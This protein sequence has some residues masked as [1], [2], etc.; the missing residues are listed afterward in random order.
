MNRALVVVA[1]VLCALPCLAQRST[2]VQLIHPAGGAVDQFGSVVAVSGDTMVV[3][4]PQDDV[5][6]FSDQGSVHVYRWTGTGW[7]FEATLIGSDSTGLDRFGW[8]VG[9]SG[10]TAVVGAYQDDGLSAD[11]G[12]AFV[13]IRT[14]GTSTWT[15]QAKL[16]A[17]DAA[18]A[19]QFGFS[20]AISGNTVV[21]G[22]NRDDVGASTDQ[23]SAYVFVRAGAIWTQQQ[24]LTASD[25]LGSDAMG[26]AVAIDGDTIVAAASNDAFGANG[27]QGSA[28]V[29]TRTGATWSQQQ[30]LFASD[31]AALDQ[32]GFSV[33]LSVTPSGDI[34]LV[35]AYQDDVGVNSNQ[36][37]A[38]VFVRSPGTAT[39]TQ[40]TKLTASDGLADDYFGSAVALSTGPGGDTALIGAYQD[41]TGANANQGAAYAFLRA[42][43]AT[44]WTQQSK[45]T[46][47]DGAAADNFG[48]AVALCGD[49]ALV[50]ANNDDLG[51]N[52]NQ[53]SAWVFSRVGSTWI[54]PDTFLS[55]STASANDFCGRSVA[56]SGDTAVVGAERPDF[57]GA[58]AQPGSAYV[59]VRTGSTWTQQAELFPSDS[60]TQDIFGH[61]VDISGD[62]VIVGNGNF[63]GGGAYI[64]V[65][66]GTT[67]SQQARLIGTDTVGFDAFGYAV[68]ISGDTAIVG[69]FADDVGANGNQGS[70]YVFVR[71]GATWTQQ[72]RLN[73]SD[74]AADDAFGTSVAI[75]GDSIVIGSDFDD[76]GANPSQGSAYCF[77]RSGTT[78]TQQQKLTDPDG[79]ASD[80]FGQDVAIAGDTIVVGS[81]NDDVG[82]RINQGSAHVFVR[83][84]GSWTRQAVLTASDGMGDGFFGESVAISGSTILAGSSARPGGGAVYVFSRSG[85]AWNQSA[86]LTE[87]TPGSWNGDGSE[88]SDAFGSGV[89]ISGDVA[90]V[91]AP[92]A[93]SGPVIDRGAAYTFDA[94]ASGY[95]LVRNDSAGQSFSSLAGALLVAGNG[96]QLAATSAAFSGIAIL[97]TLGRSFSISS[98]GPIRT[99][100]TSV[101]ALGGGSALVAPSGSPIELF[102][103]L[104]ASAGASADIYGD[105]LLLGS[106]GTLTVR[107]GASLTCNVPQAHLDGQTRTEANGYLTFS[108]SVEVNGP[109]NAAT[110]TTLT[111]TGTLTNFDTLSITSGTINAP[112]FFNRSIANFFGSTA[113]FGSF[114]NN[115]GATATIRSGTL[116]VF[117]SLANNGTILGTVC[118]GCL[119]AEA[120][121]PPGLD[122][123][124]N[125]VLGTDGNLNLPFSGAIVRV[126]ANFDCA[127]NSNAH[128]DME[129]ATLQLEGTGSEQT[130]EAMSEDIGASATGLDRTLPGHFP[131]GALEIGPSPTTVR[132]VDNR[133]N[134]GMG[135]AA[136][137][138]IYVGT[139]RID[140]G[141]HLINTGCAKIY[142]TTLINSGTVDVPANLVRLGA[143]C[144]S[145]LNYDGQ[146]DDADFVVFLFA[147]NTLDC[148]D[149]SMPAG[150]PSDLNQDGIV[151]DSD[152]VIFLAAYNELL[153]P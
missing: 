14:P 44:V 97:D 105:S 113:V 68:A 120:A 36:G 53:G 121:T 41:D 6:G 15:Q 101:L 102:G 108:G 9:I 141:S 87:P 86:I 75:S 77:V 134:D 30:K 40:Q 128:Y 46:A 107:S 48:C 148:A 76:V 103:Q 78:W 34:V 4:A 39:W 59:F 95:S 72:T 92:G 118:A 28:Y 43:G 49:T 129:S 17:S 152:F 138:A 145:D 147:Y 50:G 85:T 136:C 37:S 80:L 24:K 20:V 151:E 1:N 2:P 67:W 25:G 133:D 71:S 82:G 84:G 116:F 123:G 63:G 143:P 27:A 146:V 124:G 139:L 70:A 131:I 54:G 73:A 137:E 3:G 110:G 142:Y 150:C 83:A 21:V 93:N 5:A 69:A 38:Y 26:N 66:S 13:F 7:V 89:A 33:A 65:R 61:S 90:I 100:S 22:A 132:F 74:G 114:T 115:H 29:F 79:A 32:F 111:A 31:G 18:A 127:I 106:R 58:V 42:P 56:I 104:R 144:P 64:F 153:C 10:D 8:S 23:G 47:P 149:A 135:Q 112:L 45:L 81:P 91:G 126:G 96:D 55:G 98:S 52:I 11:S 140:S 122:V 60:F 88:F 51:P 119:S 130:L 35:G 16:I 19:D 109:V 57:Q 62:T 12:S 117:G 99:P 94:P 125:L